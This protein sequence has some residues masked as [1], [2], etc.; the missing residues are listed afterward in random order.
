MSEIKPWWKQPGECYD[1]K[2]VP[3]YPGDLIRSY[4]FK[5]YKGQVYYLYHVAVYQDKAMRMVPVSELEPTKANLGGDCLLSQDVLDDYQAEVIHGHGP[6]PYLDYDER[7]KKGKEQE[8][9]S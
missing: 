8:D 6:E 1:I 7:P 2:G 3:I 9:I 5:D 4:H